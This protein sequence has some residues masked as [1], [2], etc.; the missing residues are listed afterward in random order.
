MKFKMAISLIFGGIALSLVGCGANSNS[1]TAAGQI[2]VV[3]WGG[4]NTDARITANFNA[5]EEETGIQVTVV[6]PSDYAKLI[7]MVENNT[8]EWDVMNCDAYWGVYA[9]NNGYLE[10]MDYDVITTQIDPEVQLE[11]VMGAEIYTSVIAWNTDKYTADTSPSNWSEF[12]D[13][14]QYPGKRALWQY[15]VTVLEAALLADGVSKDDLYPLDLDRAFDK[16]DTIKDSVIWWSRGAEPSQML[17]TG[18][19]DFALAWSGRIAMAAEEGSPVD[20]TY[21]EGIMI[22][23]GWVVPKNAPNLENAML[24]IEF[25]SAAQ[26]QYAFSLQMPYG[27]TNPD[28]VALMSDELKVSLGQS[29]EQLSTELYLDNEYWAENLA[30]IEERFNAWLLLN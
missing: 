9:G 12:F 18:E 21:T 14:E 22:S 16:L 26:Q 10:P 25:I 24:F 28:A 15:P 2:V 23:A 6:T 20:M 11:Y 29:A 19:A 7:S 5:F 30:D 3:D 4:A 1:N 8:T 27:S 17:A 13:I